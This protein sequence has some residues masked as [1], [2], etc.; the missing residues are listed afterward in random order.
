MFSRTAAILVCLSFAGAAIAQHDKPAEKPAEKQ[1]AKPADKPAD[2]PA[3]PATPPAA[4]VPGQP[5]D[6]MYEAPDGT[7][8]AVV[9]KSKATFSIEIED[10]KVGTGPEVISD[11][12]I[13]INYHGTLIDGTVFNTSR[14][15]KP[16]TFPLPQLNVTGW[17]LGILG[18]K[19]GGVRRMIIPHALG[20]G[21]T[22]IPG[23]D[24]KPLV[25]AKSDLYVS[26]ELLAMNGKDAEGN[27]YPPKDKALSHVEKPNGLIIEDIKIGTGADCPEKA[28]V[29]CH[30]RGTFAVNSQEFDSSY[31]SGQPATF[32]LDPMASQP[33]IKGWQEGIPGMKVGGKRRLIIPAELAYG[34]AGRP[35]IPPNSML[36]FEVELVEVKN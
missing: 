11:A 23:P 21:D 25:P 33:V 18:M 1:P 6:G 15:K 13:T 32:S 34:A 35:G 12:V 20:Y 36:E 3:T 17:R 8:M 31:N 2:K 10:L 19:V 22:E 28:T 4:P 7:K 9:K 5:T 30:Y 26:V 14:A 16:V 29:V 27:A 24:G